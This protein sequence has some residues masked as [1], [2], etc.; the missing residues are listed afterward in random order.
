MLLIIESGSTKTEWRFIKDASAEYETHMS[1]GIN[2]YYQSPE[3]IIQAQTEA[4]AWLSEKAISHVFY[5][6]TGIT[7]EEK[8]DQIRDFL[9]PYVGE[10]QVSIENDLIAAAHALC[11]NEKGIACILGTGSN[12]GYFEGGV[13]V[14]QVPPLGFWLGDEGSGGHLGKRLVLAYLHH[15]LPTDLRDLFIKRF[16]ALGRLG[17]LAKAYQGECP[18]R[19]FASFSKFL[20]DHR[21]H[22]FCYQ[23]VVNS[24][25]NFWKSMY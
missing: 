15:E 20:F 19:W 24:L 6:G 13:L 18:N 11:G 23:L 17:I 22:P 12:S 16:G 7:G 14:E 21:R 8:K 10:A 1:P 9:L 25:R 2:P 3:E 4:I 5:Y